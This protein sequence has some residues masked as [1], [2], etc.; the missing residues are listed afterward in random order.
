M[1]Y[2]RRCLRNATSIVYRAFSSLARRPETKTTFKGK[3]KMKMKKSAKRQQGCTI[4]VI[5][6]RGH[7]S[8]VFDAYRYTN[9]TEHNIRVV[10]ADVTLQYTYYYAL[11]RRRGKM[12]KKKKRTRRDR[13]RF[14]SS[15]TYT[16]LILN[17]QEYN[18]FIYI[19]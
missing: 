1:L 2:R 4:S 13:D 9:E 10:Y 3:K 5:L 14:D 17:T 8:A 19:L 16:I 18:I 7:C 6:L 12:K 11:R 15:S